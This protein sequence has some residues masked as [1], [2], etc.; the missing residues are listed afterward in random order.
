MNAPPSQPDPHTAMAQK[1]ARLGLTIL[2]VVLGMAALAYASVPLYDM[3]CRVTGF[4]GTTQTSDAWPEQIIDRSLTIN[5]NTD[6]SPNLPWD[7]SPEKRSI[8]VKLGQKGLIAFHAKNKANTPLAG[9][10]IYNVTP[11]KAGK[12]FHKVQCFCF[13]E[14]I[15]QPGENVS[16]PVMFYIDPKMN[17][18]PNM[19]DVQTITLS[20]T[21]FTSESEELEQA[22]E[23]FY[24]Q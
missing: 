3:F 22:L 20:Y 17:D 19:D 15:L 10:A 21:F 11:L 1:N 24:N 16:M 18:D 13:D 5:F 8:E 7:F 9:S 6:T 12:Y 23:D 2:G 4:G 14:Q